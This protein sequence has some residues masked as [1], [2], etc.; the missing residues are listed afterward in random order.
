MQVKKQQLK[1]AMEQ[2][3]V[4]K[5]GKEYDKGIYSHPLIYIL[6]RVHHVKWL[7]ESH[8]GIKIAERNFNKLRYAYTALLLLL[9][10]HFSCV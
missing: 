8:A 4:L 10:S 2:L 1:P 7:D 5:L 9:V 3:T 6:C